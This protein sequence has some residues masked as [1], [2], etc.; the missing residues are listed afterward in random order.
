M[1]ESHYGFRER[2]FSLL[3]DPMF[4]YA[5][6]RH[7]TALAVLIHAFETDAGICVLS[8]APGTGKTTLLRELMRRLPPGVRV[9][10]LSNSHPSIT[11]LLHWILAAF[12]IPCE[13][14][15]RR[16]RADAFRQFLQTERSKGRR[17]LVM[18]D[19]AQNLS[20]EAIEEL[21][22]L[23]NLNAAEGPSLQ[24][25]LAGQPGLA[26][27][28]A[29]SELVPFAQRIVLNETLVALDAE[30]T[31]EYIRHRVRVAGAAGEIFEHAACDAV[32][33]HAGGNPRLINLL[34]DLCLVHGAIQGVPNITRGIVE[35]VLRDRAVRGALPEFQALDTLPA[36]PDIDTGIS[37]ATGPHKLLNPKRTRPQTSPLADAMSAANSTGTIPETVA[38]APDPA[39]NVAPASSVLTLETTSPNAPVGV[40][41]P[42]VGPNPSAGA[43]DMKTTMH[44]PGATVVPL[45]VAKP[46]VRGSSPVTG[47]K[48]PGGSLTGAFVA[49]LVVAALVTGAIFVGVGTH[50]SSTSEAEKT[51][52]AATAPAV[53]NPA[54]N[55]ESAATE[56]SRLQRERDAAIATA[57]VLERERDAALA[58]QRAAVRA[59]DA[60]RAPNRGRQGTKAAKSETVRAPA[61]RETAT[62]P[63]ENPAAALTVP[64]TPPASIAEPVPPARTAIAPEPPPVTPAPATSA[65]PP[66]VSG[67][68]PARTVQESRGFSANPCKGPSA[69]FLS[70]CKD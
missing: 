40:A 2:P 34:C 57:R 28:L 10:L 35:A 54:A 17:V 46:R 49:G 22:L 41:D 6:R 19:E 66:P 55:L 27:L 3:P 7:N 67:S 14:D 69:R 61:A 31:V 64:P 51:T 23:S 53:V 15:G 45:H 30:E 52:P 20:P 16:E 36:R 8:G 59:R 56:E 1:Y 4:L 47:D 60:K 37:D 70:T 38:T 13:G 18:L 12:A 63:A 48:S 42:G 29:S 50:R 68:A 32:F 44:T 21:R 26:T 62:D 58:A 39:R 5:S 65:A 24:W 11:E 33:R 9:G 43:A 25:I